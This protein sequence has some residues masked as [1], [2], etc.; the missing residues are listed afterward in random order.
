MITQIRAKTISEFWWLAIREALMSGHVQII[1]RG[2]FAGESHRLQLPFLT[3]EIEYPLLDQIPVTP[4]GVPAPTTQGYVDDYVFRY[5]L[6]DVKSD[7]EHYT[8]GERFSVQA[9]QLLDML[10][11]TPNTNQASVSISTP[12]DI[13]IEHPP[14]LREIDF[15]VVHGRL[16][17]TTYWRSHDLWAGLPTNLAGLAMVLCDVASAVGLGVGVLYYASSGAHLYGY[18]IDYAKTVIGDK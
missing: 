15:K 1:E 4:Q 13:F 16:N 6:G 17:M 2:S 14:C 18:Q 11:N 9:D 5:L 10:G 12:S 8:Y 3:G 7:G